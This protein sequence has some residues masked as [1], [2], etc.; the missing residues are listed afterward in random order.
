MLIVNAPSTSKERKQ[1]LGYEWSSAKGREGIKYE[2]GETVNDIITP[3]FD[4]QNLDNDRKINT[5]IK[6]NFMD[7]ITDPLPPILSLCQ[8]YRYVR[9]LVA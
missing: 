1:F 2:G 5:A 6:R 7:E 3:L 9:F 8:T 4:P